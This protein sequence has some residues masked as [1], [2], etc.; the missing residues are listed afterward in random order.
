M[1]YHV[2]THF[3][4]ALA[5]K[6]LLKIDFYTN[7]HTEKKHRKK[8]QHDIFPIT[9]DHT[10]QKYLKTEIFPWQILSESREV[11]LLLLILSDR[12]IGSFIRKVS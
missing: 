7:M 8:S 4:S 5:E 6:K 1:Q 2:P 3:K 11:L 12:K 9:I 10:T